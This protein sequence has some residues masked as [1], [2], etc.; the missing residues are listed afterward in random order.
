MREGRQSKKQ[1]RKRGKP[2]GA[3]IVLWR[4]KCLQRTIDPIVPIAPRGRRSRNRS[5]TLRGRRT[6]GQDRRGVPKE[7]DGSVRSSPALTPGQ[8]RRRRAKVWRKTPLPAP[9]EY[10]SVR[11]RLVVSSFIRPSWWMGSRSLSCR[12]PRP[13]P[14]ERDS[15]ILVSASRC[16]PDFSRSVLAG[17]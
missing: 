2:T 13:A 5:Q 7:K 9:V 3:K 11:L 15:R 10:R 6:G 16:S 4:H 12:P 14:L 17:P 8:V 1:Q